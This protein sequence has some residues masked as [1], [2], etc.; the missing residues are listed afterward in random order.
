MDLNELNSSDNTN[1]KNNDK[2]DNVK[3]KK[4]R[5][6]LTKKQQ[7]SKERDELILELNNIIGIDEKKN[8]VYLYDLEHND[9][10]IK[11]I[12]SKIE[13]IKTIF[14]TG[15]WGYFSTEKS[16][17]KDNNIGLIRSLYT[18]CD[19]EITSKLKVNTF[20][21]IKKQYTL[22]CFNKKSNN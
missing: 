6:R 20:E 15:S 1:N 16:R 12:E 10:I 18:D 9:E 21:N 13:T 4:T 11:Y 19:Y 22:L 2:N 17:G 8:Y 14:K 5:N 3:I 7:F